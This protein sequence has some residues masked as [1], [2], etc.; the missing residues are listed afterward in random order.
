MADNLRNIHRR[1]PYLRLYNIP[2][3]IDLVDMAYDG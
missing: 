1:R 2:F 3:K